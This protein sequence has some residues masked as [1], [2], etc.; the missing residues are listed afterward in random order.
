MRG[1]SNYRIQFSV[2]A[3]AYAS[4][5]ET[6]ENKI[7]FLKNIDKDST[8]SE[9]AELEQEKVNA[10]ERALAL[11]NRSL[12]VMPQNKVPF[13]R[14][15]P[16]Y[17]GSYYAVEAYDKGDALAIAAANAYKE[18]LDYYLDVDAKFS[19]SM[20]DD[21]LNA[22][23]SI[24]TIYNMT[25][26]YD[27]PNSE[28]KTSLETDINFYISSFE[29]KKKEFRN[30]DAIGQYNSTVGRFISGIQSQQQ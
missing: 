29:A 20:L 16:Y 28:L 18:E 17:V 6:S 3:D 11:L 27:T 25:T 19:K 24:F 8:A 26:A 15:M 13:G 10:K 1:V 12:E 21:A 2:A 30:A 9:I 22:M 14:V 5:Y 7:K 23:R 4:V